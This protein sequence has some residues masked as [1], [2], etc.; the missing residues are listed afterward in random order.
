MDN[1]HESPVLACSRAERWIFPRY[2]FFAVVELTE[3]V[4]AMCLQ[5]RIREISRNGCYVNT[6]NTVAVGTF[7]KAL[8]SR[9]EETF[10]TNG[11]VIYVHD[12]IGMGIAFD[13]S[14]ERQLETLNSWIAGTCLYPD[15][16]A[17]LSV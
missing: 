17:N 2:T 14:T 3:T 10:V 13:G 1:Y 8:I 6:P 9:D 4:G 12:G 11:K 7:L 5:G 15:V 16:A